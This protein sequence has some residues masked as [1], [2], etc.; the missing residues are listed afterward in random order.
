MISS[1]TRAV[2]HL[3][4]VAYDTN[5]ASDHLFSA[6]CLPSS[7]PCVCTNHCTGLC[8]ICF[9]FFKQYSLSQFCFKG[10]L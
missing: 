2:L 1:Q 7:C 8:P 9:E 6:A 5:Y 10:I 3:F 4:N